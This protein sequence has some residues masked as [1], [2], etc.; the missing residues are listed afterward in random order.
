MTK[1]TLALTLN[2]PHDDVIVYV[3]VQSEFSATEHLAIQLLVNKEF[4]LSIQLPL[5]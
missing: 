5:K 1:L 2:D 4:F 3:E